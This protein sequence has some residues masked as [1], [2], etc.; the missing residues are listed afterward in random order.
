MGQGNMLKKNMQKLYS[1]VAL[2]LILSLFLSSPNLP[3]HLAC[4][5]VVCLDT[6][7]AL[8]E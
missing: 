3:L 1:M 4:A 7:A 6:P 8:G 2:E 5:G